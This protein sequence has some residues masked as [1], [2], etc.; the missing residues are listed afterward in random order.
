[1]GSLEILIVVRECNIPL[2]LVHFLGHSLSMPH[3]LWL[4]EDSSRFN[5]SRRI[6][7]SDVGSYFICLEFRFPIDIRACGSASLDNVPW[8]CTSLGVLD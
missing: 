6:I 2:F 7:M 4:S 5:P 8:A 3:I 1:V